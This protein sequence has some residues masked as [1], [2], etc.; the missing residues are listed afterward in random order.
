MALKFAQLRRLASTSRTSERAT[1]T[2]CDAAYRNA[3]STEHH[4]LYQNPRAW[5]TGFGEIE[6]C[7]TR[8]RIRSIGSSIDSLA[9]V[10]VR[11]IKRVR[12]DTVR[13]HADSACGLG[14]GSGVGRVRVPLHWVR[15]RV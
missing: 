7:N 13:L 1:V 11:W 12:S 6:N 10:C 9:A 14:S 2:C 3:N 8:L 4:E 5:V 15:V